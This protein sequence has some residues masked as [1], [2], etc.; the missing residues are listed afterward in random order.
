MF[1]RFKD[2]LETVFK[3]EKIY[4]DQCLKDLEE[5]ENQ[6]ENVR[7]I[8]LYMAKMR[9]RGPQPHDI[10]SESA[11]DSL[12]DIQLS[13]E[14]EVE[15]LRSTAV[16]SFTLEAIKAVS[17]LR[18]RV[19]TTNKVF[20]KLL[21]YFGED[22]KKRDM[23]PHDL[24][25]IIVTFCKN[26]DKAYEEVEQIE[27]NR[28][29]EQKKREAQHNNSQNNNSQNVPKRQPVVRRQPARSSTLRV[30][31]MQP[32]MS[33]VF[34]DLRKKVKQ[35]SA[36]PAVNPMTAAKDAIINGIRNFQRPAPVPENNEETVVT[37]ATTDMKRETASPPTQQI[38]HSQE[39]NNDITPNGGISEST[40]D[41]RRET[42]SPLTQQSQHSQERNND[43]T[44]I[45]GISESPSHNENYQSHQSR[46]EN[47]IR[48][49]EGSGDVV[50]NNDEQPPQEHPQTRPRKHRSKSKDR[51]KD[52]NR[53]KSRDHKS[54][55]S[56]K[57]DKSRSKS[58]DSRRTKTPPSQQD[59]LVE[60]T[61]SAE[62]WQ[63]CPFPS[64][65]QS[66]PL[67]DSSQSVSV[68]TSHARSEPAS[69]FT[70]LSRT[71]L[72]SID[73]KPFSSSQN[74]HPHDPFNP[75]PRPTSEDTAAITEEQSPSASSF[76]SSTSNA[77]HNSMRQKIRMRR[78]R[79][80]ERRKLD[81]ASRRATSSSRTDTAPPQPQ[82]QQHQSQQQ[83][84]QHQPRQKHAV[85]REQHIVT[86]PASSTIERAAS[87]MTTSLSQSAADKIAKRRQRR[88]HRNAAASSNNTKVETTRVVDWPTNSPMRRG[89]FEGRD[90]E[91]D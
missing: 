85:S 78:Q 9:K 69:G 50:S 26:F 25:S 77:T 14:E 32:N 56:K 88:V 87:P 76:K 11:N 13:L 21:E 63:H 39:R 16:G 75:L 17:A 47:Q 15:A 5:A 55:K 2:E 23:Q 79:D 20:G 30:S 37:E 53:S 83:P 58:R 43:V 6:L 60:T 8:S 74:E 57:R 52:R 19:E 42:A 54:S 73:T 41:M 31:S 45:R 4:W 59:T 68:T 3:A 38:Q 40:T 46:G 80:M 24:F 66:A 29:R 1:E 81:E 64:D 27:K 51:K 91:M 7:L 28:Q 89:P 70:T 10:D 86:P 71:P 12:T 35:N 44:P 84:R 90:W 22:D 48:E 18:D 49:L 34:G 82:Q 36:A 65:A 61:L 72:S 62:T 33:S 67:H